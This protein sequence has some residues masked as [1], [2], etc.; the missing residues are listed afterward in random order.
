M[1]MNSQ[2]EFQICLDPSPD[3]KCAYYYMVNHLR[4]NCCVFWIDKLKLSYC[5]DAELLLC[6][7]GVHAYTVY[8]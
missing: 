5:K 3:S 7:I 1:Q 4:E 8:L 2:R 6:P